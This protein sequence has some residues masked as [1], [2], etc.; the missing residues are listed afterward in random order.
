[1]THSYYNPE[2]TSQLVNTGTVQRTEVL[3][4]KRRLVRGGPFGCIRHYQHF[5]KFALSAQR[6]IKEIRGTCTQVASLL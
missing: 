5:T 1:M 3:R 2:S 4:R 6:I